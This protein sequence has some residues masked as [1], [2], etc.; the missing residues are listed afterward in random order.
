MIKAAFFDIDGTLLSHKTK[1]VSPAVIAAIRTLQEKGIPCIVA[2]GRHKTEMDKLPLDGL[3]FD[4][5]LTLNGQLVLDRNMKFLSGVAIEGEARQLLLDMFQN[6][7]LPMLLLEQERVYLNYFAPVVKTVQD[8]IS[9]SVPPIE[10]YAGAPIYQACIYLP[11]GDHPCLE[12]LRPCSEITWWNAGG[13]DVIAKG[14]G[15]A[16]GIRQY[17][18]ATGIRREETIAFGDGENDLD[19]L[20]FAGIGV[21]M[22]N[23]EDAVK[24]AAD[25]ITDSVD[26]DGVVTALK[27]FG[28]I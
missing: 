7:T 2:T 1:R 21:A 5:Y 14:G 28:L 18:D 13:V 19:M 10:A 11:E 22:G 8:A 23:A 4:G 17:L 20:Q 27:H 25:Y 6:N 16:A 24:E 3:N 26:D 15:K 9:T 12:I